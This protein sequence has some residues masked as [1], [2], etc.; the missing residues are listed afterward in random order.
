M[1]I[2]CGGC[3]RLIAEA[4]EGHVLMKHRGRIVRIVEGDLVCECGT[5]TPIRAGEVVPDA[6]TPPAVG[7]V[8]TRAA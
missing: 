7:R 8:A 2:M 3:G 5:V 4:A 1:Y 6:D